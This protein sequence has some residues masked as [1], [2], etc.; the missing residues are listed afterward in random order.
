MQYWEKKQDPFENLEAACQRSAVF[1]S[2]NN[3]FE[4]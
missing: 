3:E 4:D 2:R 1:S